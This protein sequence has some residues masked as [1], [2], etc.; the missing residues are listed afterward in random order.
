MFRQLDPD[1]DDEFGE[2]TDILHNALIA[3]KD[4]HVLT[5]CKEAGFDFTEPVYYHGDALCLRDECLIPCYGIGV[6]QKL[7]ELGVDLDEAVVNGRTPANLIARQ[8]ASRDSQSEA[9]FEQ[10]A[11]FFSGE[12]MAQLDSF[13]EAAI[14]H[15]A[16]EGHTGMLKIMIEKGVDV[17]LSKDAPAPAGTTPLH[18]ACAYGHADAVKLLI[19][20]GADDTMK[21]LDGETPAHIALMHKKSGSP[22]NR[23]ERVQLLRELTHIDIARNDGRTPLMLLGINDEELIP[24]FLE[25]G[26]DVNRTDNQGMTAMML[27]PH[28][29]FIKPL[30]KAGADISLADNDGNT[31]LHHALKESSQ[32][33]ARYLIK[34]GADYNRPNNEGETPAQIAIEKGFD[35]VLALMTKIE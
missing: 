12:S 26:V 6:L 33:T 15:A 7:S 1:D 21:N 16:R 22:L 14:H 32:E 11:A 9:Y 13:G 35:G 24:L 20:A 27:R 4:A 3:D 2:I 29:E 18:E 31:V 25:R 10:A 5:L 17:N 8:S 19:E 28:K 30:L 23:D 34:K